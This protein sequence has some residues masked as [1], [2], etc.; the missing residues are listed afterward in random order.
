MALMDSDS[1][2]LRTTCPRNPKALIV[3]FFR[4]P[5]PLRPACLA[6]DRDAVAF[7]AVDDLRGV[8]GLRALVDLLAE[9]DL[10]FTGLLAGL[11][12]D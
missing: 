12:F 2:V 8:A 9:L 11:T 5:T 1:D 6:G 7:R 4:G 3:R 10:R